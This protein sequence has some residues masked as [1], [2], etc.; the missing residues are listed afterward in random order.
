M[1]Y[2]DDAIFID[3][4]FV[5]RSRDTACIFLST[6]NK[7]IQFNSIQRLFGL[8]RLTLYCVIQSWIQCLLKFSSSSRSSHQRCSIEK[9]VL[10]NFTKFTGK[11]HSPATLLKKRLAQAFSCEFCEIFQNSLFAEHVWTT[12]STLL[13]E[14]A[15][16]V[17]WTNQSKPSAILI[18][19]F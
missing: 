17:V 15:S 19:I 13:R 16:V 14:L 18:E 6:W 3:I 8:W 2:S 10:K 5:I 9:G 1:F 12:A 7:A 11:G 4:Y